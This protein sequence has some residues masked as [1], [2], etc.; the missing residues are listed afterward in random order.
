MNTVDEQYLDDSPCTDSNRFRPAVSSKTSSFGP[1]N[2]VI[3]E[4]TTSITLDQSTFQASVPSTPPVVP[5]ENQ[6]TDDEALLESLSQSLY[7]NDHSIL[8]SSNWNHPIVSMDVPTVFAGRNP[9]S[10]AENQEISSWDKNFFILTSAGK[11]IYAMHGSDGQVTSLM[12]IINTVMSY[13]QLHNSSDIRTIS[14][15]KAKLAFLD[16]SPIFLAA[17]SDRGETSNELINQLDFLHSYLLSSL[18]QRQLTRFFSRRE[19][20][21]LRNF[22]EATDFENLD[23]ICSLICERLYP[24][25]LLGALQCL[26]LKKTHRA[27]IHEAMLQCL[28]KESDLPRGTL[29]Y[30]LIVAPD[31]K[32]CSVLRPR[33]HT[34]HTTD[35]NLLFCLIFHHF[36]NLQDQQEMWV[37]IC[38]PKFNSSGFL[39][40]YIKLLPNSTKA[41]PETNSGKRPVLVLISAQKDAFFS[42]KTLGGNLFK[43]LQANSLIDHIYRAKGIKISDIPAPLVHH[44]IYKS[45][46]HVQYIIPELQFVTQAEDES[47]EYEKK[48]I[49]YYQL[50][51]NSVFRDNGSAHSKSTLNFVQWEAA[52]AVGER[53]FEQAVFQRE[54]ICMMGLA[55]TTPKFE[56][57]L[58][59]NNGTNDKNA[60]LKSAKKIIKWCARHEQR[61]F[62]SDGAVF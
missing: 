4:P 30:G 21:D 27:Q 49:T 40:C 28:L 55:W 6:D 24:D 23:E 46:K 14:C 39:Y 48:I 60:V 3:S 50:I 31:N 38:F 54:K 11:P 13:F 45:K 2:G 22:L 56:L 33:G 53:S 9:V 43:H 32:L 20:F 5:Q 36:Q 19:N 26:S 17:Y 61:L 35:L 59:C 1:L 52:E 57:Y 15:G 44:F 29:L 42:L 8:G 62:L 25:V 47:Q 7:S 16:R 18:S 34:L 41:G 10:S 37:P 58:I 51:H 12:G